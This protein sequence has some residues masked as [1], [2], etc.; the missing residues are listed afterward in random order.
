[1]QIGH[2]N[3]D[4]RRPLAPSF[5]RDNYTFVQS[6][7]PLARLNETLH[8]ERE[9]TRSFANVAIRLLSKDNIEGR[10]A[11]LQVCMFTVGGGETLVFVNP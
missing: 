1:V 6:L 9:L 10:Q 7:F 11:L 3:K 8:P 5:F 2:S 4:N